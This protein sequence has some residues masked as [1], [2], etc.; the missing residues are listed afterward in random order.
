MARMITLEQ[1]IRIA[2]ESIAVGA[3]LAEGGHTI[4]DAA[5][6]FRVGV[7]TIRNRLNTLKYIKNA[8]YRLLYLKAMQQLKRAKIGKCRKTKI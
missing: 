6:E 5:E 2:E 8:R 1:A 3:Y 4:K 7:T